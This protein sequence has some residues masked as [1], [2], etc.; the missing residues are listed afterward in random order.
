MIL[1]F[2]TP[3]WETDGIGGMLT[4]EDSH[5]ILRKMFLRYNTHM[6]VQQTRT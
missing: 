1:Y 6:A 3:A 5:Q 4:P 2:N